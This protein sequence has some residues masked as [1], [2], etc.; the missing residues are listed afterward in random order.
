MWVL[1]NCINRNLRQLAA[2]RDQLTELFG[3]ILAA[4]QIAPIGGDVSLIAGVVSALLREADGSLPLRERALAHAEALRLLAQ[5]KNLLRNNILR[6]HHK[7]RR[8]V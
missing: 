7:I 8:G 4:A 1:L 3:I 6:V 2:D 5:S